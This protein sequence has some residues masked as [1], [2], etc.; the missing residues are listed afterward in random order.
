MHRGFTLMEVIVVIGLL[1]VFAVMGLSYS[2]DSYRG[3]LFRS[4]YTSFVNML[5][6]A[7]N[8]ALNNFNESCHGITILADE[9]RIFKTDE[10]NLNDVDDYK[11][12]PRNSSLTFDGPDT[13]MFDQLTGNLNSGSCDGDDPCTITFGYGLRTKSVEINRFGGIA[14]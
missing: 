11:G 10:C 5:A 14:W 8:Q 1:A 3:Y 4:E 6:K 9:Y 7:R 2:F 12:F 13:I